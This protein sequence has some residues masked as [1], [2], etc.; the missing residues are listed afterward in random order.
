M[1]P[2]RSLGTAVND[3]ARELSH[4]VCQNSP[5]TRAEETFLLIH[6]P[7]TTTSKLSVSCMMTPS[8]AALYG[9]NSMG[10]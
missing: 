10:C 5:S 7:S 9:E 1:S 4:F 8:E 6:A 3:H 2:R